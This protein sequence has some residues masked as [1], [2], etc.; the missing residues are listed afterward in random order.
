MGRFFSIS[1]Y[2]SSGCRLDR[3]FPVVGKNDGRA[4]LGE[5]PGLRQAHTG[6][7]PSEDLILTGMEVARRPATRIDFRL[8][9][10]EITR[11]LAGAED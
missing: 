4:G 9:E 8:H 1:A 11:N 5:C 10:Q 3:V 7:S 2:A 6:S